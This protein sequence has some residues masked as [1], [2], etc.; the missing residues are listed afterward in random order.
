MHQTSF[1]PAGDGMAYV[2]KSQICTASNDHTDPACFGAGDYSWPRW[3]PDGNQLVYGLGD[4]LLVSNPDG[5]SQ[6]PLT[7]SGSGLNRMGTWSPDGMKIA[8]TNAASYNAPGDLWTVNPD[9]TDPQQIFSDVQWNSYEK[10]AW[11]PNGQWLAVETSTG[12]WLV[13]SDGAQSQQ[14]PGTEG[15]EYHD[16]TWSPSN[17]GWPLFYSYY[18]KATSQNV[19]MYLMNLESAPQIFPNAAWGPVW[20]GDGRWGAIGYTYQKNGAYQSKIYVFQIE[21]DFWP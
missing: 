6:I 13:S 2:H 15:F 17:T 10:L 12:I 5:T 4:D 19:T 14:V 16:I 18:D 3:S 21:P 7:D 1:N 11:N 8:Y 20:S 9:G